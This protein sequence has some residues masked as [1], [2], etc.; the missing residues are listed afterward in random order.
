MAIIKPTIGLTS[1]ANDHATTADRGPG[2]M[3][4]SLSNTFSV[5]IMADADSEFKQQI[6]TLSGTVTKILDGNQEAERIGAP[7]GGASGYVPGT[8]GCWVYMKNLAAVASSTELILVSLLAAGNSATPTAPAGSGTTALD[9]E[10]YQS[11]RT[12]TLK[13][14]EACFFPFDYIGD[15]YVESKAGTPKLEFWRWDR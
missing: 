4:L 2:T 9:V 14:S 8:M 11:L 6:L 1:Y 7:G 12:F 10:S 13:P 15:I 5:T 3:S